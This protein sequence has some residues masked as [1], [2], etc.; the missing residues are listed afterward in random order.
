MK[1]LQV[2]FCRCNQLF[3]SCKYLRLTLSRLALTCMLEVEWLV[4]LVLRSVNCLSEIF[5]RLACRGKQV[6]HDQRDPSSD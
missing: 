5:S 4:L 6:L 1:W 2:E 3:G